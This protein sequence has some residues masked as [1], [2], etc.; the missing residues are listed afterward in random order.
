VASPAVPSATDR[1]QAM[2]PDEIYLL[3]TLVDPAAEPIQ[4]LRAWR[5]TDGESVEVGLMINP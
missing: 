1:R 4:A 3:A 2:Y 5:I